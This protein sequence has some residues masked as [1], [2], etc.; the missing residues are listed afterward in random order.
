M[1]VQASCAAH[2]AQRIVQPNS[3]PTPPWHRLQV[4]LKGD[5][6]VLLEP[7]LAAAAAAPAG[8]AAAAPAA[9]AAAPAPA[10]V[11]SAASGEW[12]EEQ[13]LALV[14]ALKQVGKDAEDRWG[15]VGWV[16][17]FSCAGSR[18]SGRG[19]RSGG[20][21]IAADHRLLELTSRLHMCM[22]S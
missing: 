4:N 2:P 5:A 1:Q 3:N 13:E 11:V 20:A 21:S 10:T 18:G 22:G 16:G 19:Q 6:A 17:V 8:G 7:G 15:Q 9:A 12:S 14:K